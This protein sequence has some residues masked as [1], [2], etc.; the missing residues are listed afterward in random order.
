[1]LIGSNVL[2]NTRI[3]A[4]IKYGNQ[5][6]KLCI[7]F[8]CSVENGLMFPFQKDGHFIKG[9]K[10]QVSFGIKNLF[11]TSCY[12]AKPIIPPMIDGNSGPIITQTIHK[13]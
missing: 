13:E 4:R 3:I 2:E 5:A 10:S 7:L 6:F 8:F 9:S 11:F 12:G 1:M